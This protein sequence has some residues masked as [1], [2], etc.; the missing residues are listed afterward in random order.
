[1]ASRKGAALA[2][3]PPDGGTI[4]P[5]FGDLGTCSRRRSHEVP[6]REHV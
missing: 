2:I 1:M 5:L 3:S 6:I 4:A